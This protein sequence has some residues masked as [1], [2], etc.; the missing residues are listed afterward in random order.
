MDARTAP[1]SGRRMVL[2]KEAAAYLGITVKT[3]QK[4]PKREPGFPA[5]WLLGT[6]QRR[7]ARYDIT[8]IAHWLDQKNGGGHG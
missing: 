3:L 6:G 7:A 8:A 5:P 4:L 2:P 1:P